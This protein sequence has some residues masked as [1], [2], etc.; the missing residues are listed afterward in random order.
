MWEGWSVID[1]SW[2]GSAALAFARDTGGGAGACPA[3]S[4]S[5][6]CVNGERAKAMSFAPGLD[7]MFRLPADHC[8]L[9]ATAVVAQLAEHLYLLE[10]VGGSSPPRSSIGPLLSSD[11]RGLLL[12][13]SL[14]SV[15]D[16]GV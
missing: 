8:H 2:A 16:R 12:C 7:D 14:Y 3:A 13:S 6:R 15:F 5:Q 11:T 10:E 4:T 1:H 9:D